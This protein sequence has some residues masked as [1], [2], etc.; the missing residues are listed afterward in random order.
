MLGLLGGAGALALGVGS[1]NFFNNEEMPKAPIISGKSLCD[2]H[3]HLANDQGFYETLEVLSSPGIIGLTQWYG[4]KDILTYE[5]VKDIFRKHIHEINKDRFAQIGNGYIMKT[6]EIACDFHHFLA[7]GCEEP[8][9]NDKKNSK[10]EDLIKAIHDRGGI[11]ILNHP[12]ITWEDS[13]RHYRFINDD[14]EKRVIEISNLV[15]EIEMFNAFSINPTLGL[16]VENMKEANV[17]T[18]EL[19]K[20]SKFKGTVSSDTHKRLEQAKLCGIYIDDKNLTLDKVQ[21]SITS[22]DFDN[23]YRSYISRWSFVRSI[24]DGKI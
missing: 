23:D 17:K 7:I 11:A 21:K 5:I 15:D 6:Q 1:Y 20:S 16:Y 18:E 12:Y 10:V 22:G 4:R 24:V 9:I 3:A 2:S 13:L 19:V 14:E 8:Y